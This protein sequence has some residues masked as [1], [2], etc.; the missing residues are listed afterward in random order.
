MKTTVVLLCGLFFSLDLFGAFLPLKSNIQ[1][2]T[3]SRFGLGMEAFSRLANNEKIDLGREEKKEVKL[4]SQTEIRQD[5]ILDL[6]FNFSDK[7]LNLI[8]ITGLQ[9]E[10]KFDP[11][12]IRYSINKPNLKFERDMKSFN[13]GRYTTFGN[14]YLVYG[15]A[16]DL[17]FLHW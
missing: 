10:H 14:A 17:G 3:F 15:L 16:S 4:P 8:T 11:S 9:Q 12:L 1:E 2:A 13:D 7:T 6:A 5:S